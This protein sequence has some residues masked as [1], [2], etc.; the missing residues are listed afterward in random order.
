MPIPFCKVRVGTMWKPEYELL[1]DYNSEVSRGIV[2]TEEWR[3]KME[4]IQKDFDDTR[5]KLIE[6]GEL[7]FI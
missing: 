3:E 1:A 5:R 6:E 7:L 4:E 2:H